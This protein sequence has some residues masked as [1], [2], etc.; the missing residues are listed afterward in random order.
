MPAVPGFL[1]TR[2][3]ALARRLAPAGTERHRFLR[4]VLQLLRHGIEPVLDRGLPNLPQLPDPGNAGSA[5][6]VM[7]WY[8]HDPLARGR[9]PLA[10]LPG[11][12]GPCLTW[13]FRHCDELKLSTG[14]IV[15][16]LRAHAADPVAAIDALYRRHPQWQR[17]VP[18]GLER[19]DEL[20]TWLEAR[21][22]V[23][24]FDE[25]RGSSPPAL[26]D[27]IASTCSAGMT[28][29]TRQGVN[30]LG[31]FRYPSGIQ[32]AAQNAVLALRQVGW[33]VSCRDVPTGADLPNRDGYL[34]MH[35]YPVTISHL[36]PE[37]H[38]M[39]AYPLAGL[40]PR[41]NTYRIGT[42]YWEL[43]RAPKSWRRHVRWLHEIWAPTPFI[44]EAL[45]GV[46]PMPVVDMLP[47]IP[48]PSEVRSP[49]SRWGL[50]EDRYLFLFSFD[51]NSTMER[52]NPLAAIVAFRQ[53]FRHDEPVGLVV[54]VSRGDSDPRG[55]RALQAACEPGRVW[56]IDEVLDDMHGL[57]AACDAYVSLHRSEGFGLTMAEAMALGK[58]TIAT[59]YSGNLAFM[60]DANS[61]LVDHAM[62]PVVGA[63]PFYRPGCRWA[64]PSVAHAARLMRSFVDDQAAARELGS[65]GR[66]AVRE[67]LS[68]EAA[69][70]RMTRRLEVI[71]MENG[72]PDEF[73]SGSSGRDSGT[74]ARRP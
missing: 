65:R 16:C 61:R 71:A 8:D 57:M 52:K 70:R 7:H 33:D 14:D 27:R 45:R 24:C 54:K 67:S 55:L 40:Q 36:P 4:R 19:P 9:F 31:H 29:A 12:E 58:P 62:S 10:L 3:R 51:M 34:G 68:L 43:E 30:V 18:D 56:L 66:E 49:R 26:C 22:G 15:A 39:N 46:V 48:M 28:P 47:G 5:D 2:F 25:R 6:A 13:L 37:P 17:A 11:H 53:A 20:W 60:N 69:G 32:V 72:T 21:Y 44:A 63:G 41:P 38:G 35:P 1:D 73:G 50:P 64:E 23:R 74:P 59:G 42:W